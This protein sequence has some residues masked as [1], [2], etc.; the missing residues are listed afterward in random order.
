VPFAAVHAAPQTEQFAGSAWRF[1]SQPFATIPSQS[2]NP[3]AQVI[4]HRPAAQ[5]GVP[6][7]ALHTLV[8]EP[9]CVGSAFRFTSQPFA[10]LPSQFAKPGLQVIPHAPAVQV[11]APLFVLQAVTQ[12]PQWVGSALRFTSQPFAALPS[13]F[14]NPALQVMPQTP[15]LH[16]AVPFVELQVPPQ[17]P[18]CAGSTL[19]FTSQPFEA[20][21]SQSA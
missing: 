6:L 16:V 5:I 21:P 10:A 19:R 11:A 17:L 8:H 4:P 13:Q 15:A 14:P 3:G 7:F 9:Q 12:A 2:A 1:T 20:S 18:Q